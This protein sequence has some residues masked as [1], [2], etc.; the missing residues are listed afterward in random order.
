MRET[1]WQLSKFLV[2]GTTNR[3]R[4]ITHVTLT[5]DELV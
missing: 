4:T 1:R 2:S 3:K 5:P